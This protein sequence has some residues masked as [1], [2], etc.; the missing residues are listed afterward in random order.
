MPYQIVTEPTVEPL[1]LTEAKTHLRV[2]FSADD[3]L[4]TAMITAVRQYAE[5]ITQR[6]LCTASWRYVIDSFPGPARFAIPYGSTLSIPS[7]AIVLNKAPVKTVTAV[8]YLDLAGVQQTMPAADYT[9]DY[10]SAPCRITP[11]FGRIWP[12]PLPQIGAIEVD[13]D[14]GYGAAADVPQGIKNWMLLRLGALYENREELSVG[15][16][17]TVNPLPFVDGLLDG[18]KVVVY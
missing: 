15:E 7:H 6:Q 9:V 3:T 16:R 4:I 1:S 12:I 2:D 13:F 10:T 8:K 17:I 18:Y 14:A 5:T 11:I